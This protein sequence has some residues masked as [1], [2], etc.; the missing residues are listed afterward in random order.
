[1]RLW[2][3][4]SIL[5]SHA[6]ILFNANI[7]ATSNVGE[8]RHLLDRSM[9]IVKTMYNYGKRKIYNAITFAEQ[10]LRYNER[11]ID[12]VAVGYLKSA[13]SWIDEEAKRAPRHRNLRRLS[14]VVRQRLGRL[15]A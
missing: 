14:K 8:L 5:P 4:P 3:D 11:Y 13:A 12:G 6:V 1:M 10:A 9:E 15:A 7:D 2:I